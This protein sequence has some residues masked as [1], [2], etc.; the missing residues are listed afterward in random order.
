MNELFQAEP[1]EERPCP[2]RFSIG[3]I[4]FERDLWERMGWFDVDLKSSGM[5]SDEVQLCKYC[6]LQSRPLMVSENIVAGHFSFGKQ[7]EEMKKYY[8]R[9]VEKFKGAKNETG[10]EGGQG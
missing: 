3:A 5:G 7:N 10:H 2:I 8:A 1:L 4:L 9:N 6:M